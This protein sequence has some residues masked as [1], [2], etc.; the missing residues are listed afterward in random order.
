MGCPFICRW[1]L[2]ACGLTWLQSPVGWDWSHLKAQLGC[3]SKRA[4]SWLAGGAGCRLGAHLR[5]SAGM[6]T[7]DLS[8]WLGFRATWQLDSERVHPGSACSKRQKVEAAGP[9][10]PGPGIQDTV[11]S[12]KRYWEGT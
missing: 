1:A 5:Q 8:V 2:L 9:L 3:M 10:K 4:H 11:T 6:Y 12:A 7:L